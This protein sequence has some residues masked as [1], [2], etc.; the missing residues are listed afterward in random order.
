MAENVSIAYDPDVWQNDM[1]FKV[2]SIFQKDIKTNIVLRCCSQDQDDCSKRLLC[3][4]NARAAAGRS[5]SPNEELIAQVS[6]QPY[7]IYHLS[8]MI[9]DI[10]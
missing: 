8:Y 4:L 7:I 5:L 10:S 1:I 2:L 3:E 9:Y 6:S